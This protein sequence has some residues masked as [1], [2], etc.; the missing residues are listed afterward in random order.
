MD[1]PTCNRMQKPFWPTR[2]LG[3]G[4]S[5]YRDDFQ[6][7]RT[8]YSISCNTDIVQRLSSKIVL[9]IR[10]KRVDNKMRN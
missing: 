4:N 5:H 2:F 9:S 7:Y 1:I 8:L 10:G 3:L 6:F